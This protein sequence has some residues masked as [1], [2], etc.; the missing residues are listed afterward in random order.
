M[1][2]DASKGL[3]M[4]FSIFSSKNTLQVELLD[5]YPPDYSVIHISFWRYIS[6]SKSHFL[7]ISI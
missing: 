3:W 7:N 5:H 2:D 1:A 6:L 4:F